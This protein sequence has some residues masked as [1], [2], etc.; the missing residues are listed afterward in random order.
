MFGFSL[1][2]AEML[3]CLKLD[4][5]VVAEGGCELGSG[6]VTSLAMLHGFSATLLLQAG[7]CKGEQPQHCRRKC[8][9]V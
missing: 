2:L 5:V 4:S 1:I 8:P 9:M 7:G 6:P 3:D